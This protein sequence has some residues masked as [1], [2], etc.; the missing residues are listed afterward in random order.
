M[1]SSRRT[2]SVLLVVTLLL[3]GL[4]V[5]T[6]WQTEHRAERFERGQKFLP[7]LDPDEIDGIEIRQKEDRV[8]LER[9]AEGDRFRVANAHGYRADT[10]RV[11]RLLRDLL[12]LGLEK[13]VGRSTPELA[14]ELGVARLEGGALPGETLEIALLDDAG[15]DM[16]RFLMGESPEDLQGRYVRRVPPRTTEDEPS[17]IYITR[18]GLSAD[19]EPERWVDQEI[20]DVP[21]S[22]IRAIRGDGFEIARVPVDNPG[23]NPVEK[24]VEKELESEDD[25]A[26]ELGP[27]E[28]RRPEGT[29]SGKVGSVKRVLSP[30]RFQKHHLADA[31]E[32]RDLVFGRALEVELRDGSA[33]RLELATRG[34]QHFL[35]V[36][37]FHTLGEVYLDRDA[38]ED[39]VRETSDVLLRADELQAFAD[40][41]GSW[42][43]E[44][45]DVTAERVGVESSELVD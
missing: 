28:L 5:F 10:A 20:L 43:Y 6:W 16:V 2:N 42:I 39:E 1:R 35:R 36:D 13:E 40:Y 34:E 44:V 19:V 31:E 32:V 33:Y 45:S 21:R 25:D 24:G 9:T 29:P 3:L 27:L 14:E 8:L 26:P 23:E 38:S 30:L 15:E 4:S 37:A 11:N 22:E 41:H 12:E 7:N 18:Q 17:T